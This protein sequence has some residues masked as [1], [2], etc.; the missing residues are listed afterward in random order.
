MTSRK[1][2]LVV[3]NNEDDAF[4]LRRTLRDLP[5]C[6]SFLCRSLSEARA[7]LSRTGIY[8]DT[9]N[10]PAPDAVI[11]ELRLGTDSGYELLIWMRENKNLRSI[12]VYVLAGAISP[13]DRATLTGMGIRRVVEKPNGNEELKRL[14]TD[15]ARE[16]CGSE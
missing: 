4:L 1:H 15:L 13:H 11:T 14:L 2:I 12:P 9:E 3:E 6:T 5:F 16:V 10:Y 7:Y 8:K